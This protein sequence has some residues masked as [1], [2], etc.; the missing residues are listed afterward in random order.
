MELNDLFQKALRFEFLTVEEGM[1]L[2]E[3]AAL[4][5]LMFVAD[6]LRKKQVPHG[7]VTWQIDRNVNT[8]NVCIANCKFCNFYRIPGH[9]EAYITDI[10]TYKTKIEETIK[11]GGD[12]LLL[13]GGHH[14]E[15][16]LGFYVNL[17]KELKSLYPN[18]KLHTLGPPEVAHITK[19]EKS[20]H[21]EVLMALKEAGMDSLPGAGAE[22]LTDR[23]RRLISKGKCGAQE[24][25]DIMHEAH[26]LNITTSATMMFGHVETLQER[27]EHLVKLRE[28]QSRKPAGAKGFLAFIPWTFQDVD[29]LLA[30]IRGVHNLTTT[31]EYIRMIAI[32]R[33]M[34]PNILNIQASWLTVG[35][36]VAQ[37]CLNAGAND[38]GSIMIEENVVSAAGAPHRFTSTTIQAA[39]KEAG[40]EPQLRNQQYEWREI[41]ESIVEQ[42]VNY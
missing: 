8:T 15:L 28:V 20:T 14:P 41:P 11:F 39:I 35:K 10:E 30:K 21:R 25:L 31:E 22:I 4:T 26:K 17:F 27:F 9:A 23:V 16:G 36:Q 13:Q 18:I 5:E 7:K 38:F 40:F 1:F 19:L 34:L 33:I 32:S 42:V 12:Q 2:Y 6:E 24:W 3:N 37:I 29:T